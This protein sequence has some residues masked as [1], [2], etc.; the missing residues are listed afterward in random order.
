MAGTAARIVVSERQQKLQHRDETPCVWLERRFHVGSSCRNN[1][2]VA[3]GP[4]PDGLR[5]TIHQGRKTTSAV[6]KTTAENPFRSLW[7]S[8][9]VLTSSGCGLIP[10]SS[11]HSTRSQ[12]LSSSSHPLGLPGHP[13]IDH[14]RHSPNVSAL[15]R[16]V[17]N[18]QGVR[19]KPGTAFVRICEKSLSLGCLTRRSS[20]KCREGMKKLPSKPNPFAL[21]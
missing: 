12:T 9:A 15:A 3:A 6:I 16:R 20:L 14:H 17:T 2:L 4:G 21:F 11:K 13:R 18:Q 10:N 8:I 19:P 5:Q 7:N 1:N